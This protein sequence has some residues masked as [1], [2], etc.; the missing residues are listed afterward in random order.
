MGWI[1]RTL[2]PH[3]VSPDEALPGRDTPI[4]DP[5]PRHKLI[6]EKRAT[7]AATPEQDAKRPAHRTG[8]DNLVLAGDWVQNGL[9]STI[10][11]SLRS[12]KSAAA[13]L[14]AA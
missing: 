10:E 11:G 6:T 3:M 2:K 1:Q 8:L 9:P 12:G 7:F 4:L 5:M 14:A 13:L